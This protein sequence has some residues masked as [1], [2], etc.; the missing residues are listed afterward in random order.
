MTAMTDEKMAGAVRRAPLLDISAL[1]ARRLDFQVVA[2][3]I[4]DAVVETTDF[5][6]ATLTVREGDRC[7]RLA[8]AGLVDGRI[9]MTTP[10]EHWLPLLLASYRTG[11]RSYLIPPEVDADW[12]D[13]PD[14]DTVLDGPDAWTAEHGL[15]VTLTNTEDEIIGFVAVDEPTSGRLPTAETVETLEVLGAQAQVAFAMAHLYAE[16]RRQAMVREKLFD[17]GKT[18]AATTDFSQIMQ[19]MVRAIREHLDVLRVTVA[20]SADGQAEYF[21]SLP[22]QADRISASIGPLAAPR[23]ALMEEVRRLGHLVISDLRDRPEIAAFLD[24]RAKS[25]LGVATLEGEIHIGLSVVSE[26]PGAFDGEDVAFLSGLLDL[27]VVALRNADLYE[28]VRFAAE[29][30]ALTGLRNRRVFWDVLHPLLDEAT[31]ERPLALGMVDIDDFKQ[32]NDR[33]GH[34]TGDRALR[35]VASR[36]DSSVR[37]TDTVFRIGGEEFVVVMPDTGPTEAT[38]VL[39]RVARAVRVSRL[40]LPPVT[41]SAGVAVA[42]VHATDADELFSIADAALYKAKHGGKDRTV[43]SEG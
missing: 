16:A 8:T 32:I 20:K 37:Q 42:P 14:L 23:R 34:V 21:R 19:P 33:H 25:F 29:R 4:C 41:I 26:D 9:G 28:E 13:I 18:M 3:R 39:E 35:H 24:P 10:F 12:A 31:P 40:D 43:L 17:I 38:R 22:E 11:E 36:L 6:V 30:D 2:Q 15:V 5:R 1:V 27:T 7:R